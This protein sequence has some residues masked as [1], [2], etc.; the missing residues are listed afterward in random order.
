MP[1][2]VYV[3]NK[4]GD[5]LASQVGS[6]GTSFT[7]AKQIKKERPDLIV[8]V[9]DEDRQQLIAKFNGEIQRFERKMLTGKSSTKMRIPRKAM[10]P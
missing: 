5:I 3:E 4:N 2:L 8:N 9:Y 6:A 7:L 1:V 10:Q